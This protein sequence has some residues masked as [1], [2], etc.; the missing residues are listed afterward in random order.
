L[1]FD[2]RKPEIYVDELRIGNP[3][4]CGCKPIIDVLLGHANDQTYRLFARYLAPS[5]KVREQ[6]RTLDDAVEIAKSWLL[7]HLSPEAEVIDPACAITIGGR[8]HICKI[9]LDGTV[10]WVPGFE[11]RPST[12]I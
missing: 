3:T 11:Y 2:G 5:V 8:P 7:C 10:S 12:H 4:G 6:E 9:K 1:F